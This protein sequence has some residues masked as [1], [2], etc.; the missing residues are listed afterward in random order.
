MI[1]ISE[2][3]RPPT[4]FCHSRCDLGKTEET[5]FHLV[6]GHKNRR[7]AAFIV[8]CSF[9]RGLGRE[10]G[11]IDLSVEYDG[12][13]TEI[14]RYPVISTED[15]QDVHNYTICVPPIYGE[16]PSLT[17]FV[18]FMEMNRILGATR[19]VFYD[20][21]LKPDVRNAIKLYQ[22]QGVAILLPWNLL[23]YVRDF[24][25]IHYHGQMVAIHDCLYRNRGR[26]RWVGFHDLDEFIVPLAYPTIPLLLNEV[27]VNQ[28]CGFCIQST[29][30]PLNGEMKVQ[31]TNNSLVTQRRFLRTKS[32]FTTR[33][34]CIV[35]PRKV[36]ELGIH[37][38][39][40]STSQ[41]YGKSSISPKKA[42]V[43]H[44]RHC[45]QFEDLKA[46]CRNLVP[47]TFMK[48]YK[49]RIEESI[50]HVMRRLNT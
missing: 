25:S 30:F 43:F 2:T 20:L 42:L 7:H 17:N 13:K 11:F 44:Y 3:F 27:I 18:E 33:E 19:F 50:D 21:E 1:A 37:L 41:Q 32:T 9:P 34:K 36:F 14:M 16:G 47:E 6:N 29:V 35:D 22:S 23:V 5:E 24:Y 31:G 38:I 8:S 45:I 48:R 12:K 49:T 40:T 39:M 46:A 10:P 26:S 28:S 15:V 4:V